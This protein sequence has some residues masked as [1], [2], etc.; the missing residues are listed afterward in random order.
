MAKSVVVIKLE[1]D[2]MTNKQGIIPLHKGVLEKLS[3]A[4]LIV[5]KDGKIISGN[6]SAINML[7]ITDEE[8]NVDDYLD[9]Q[10]LMSK[11][12]N[13]LIMEQK[14]NQDKLLEVSSIELNS[15]LYCLIL[16]EA[17]L[18]SQ[19]TEIK[20]YIDR[21]LKTNTIGLVM[22]YKDIIID[23]DAEFAHIFG[24]TTS[25]LKGKALTT[26]LEK[27]N[28]E[29]VL[30]INYNDCEEP[31]IV[32][33]IRKN[34][35]TFYA[36]FT[37][38]LFIESKRNIRIASVKNVTE[39]VEAEKRI[40]FMAN[41]D[42]LTDLPNRNF[43]F[44][45]LKDAIKE[46]EHTDEQLAVHFINLDYFKEINETFGYEVG[47]KLLKMC[48]DKFKKYLHTNTFIA[49]MS[50]DEF[51]I[52]Q[53]A[54]T[55]KEEAIDLVKKIL[56]DFKHP[57]EIDGH[58]I[59]TSLSIG[60]SLYPLNGL[61]AD[62]LVKRADSAMYIIKGKNRNHYNFF[63]S[64]I[65]KE[66]RTMIKMETELRKALTNNQL[67]LHY[68]PQKNLKSG[69]VIGV[70]ALLRWNHPMKGNIPPMD[71]IPLAEKTGLIVEIGDWVLRK[72]CQ[73]NK[74][75]QDKG[76][77][78]VIVSVNLSARQFHQKDV[79]DKIQSILTE[80]GLKPQ[81]LELEITE[82]MAMTN[83]KFI[84]QTMNRL[85]N[86]GVLVSIDDFGTGY[87]SLKS[88]SLFP[89]TKLKIDK[90]FMAEDQKHNQAIVRSIIKMSHSLNMKVIA[91]GVETAKQLNFLKQENCDE[92]QGFYFSKPLPPEQLTKFLR[93][94]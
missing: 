74:A 84:L 51:L 6:Q 60:I 40:E 77:Q 61:T 64:A 57:I 19:T 56:S 93:S 9:F 11:H 44:R 7:N 33:G 22:F 88:L 28:R 3:D 21:L 24:Y 85:R 15:R 90:M 79:V 87:S 37:Q 72:A 4:L 32:T 50:G 94:I 52:L 16:N 63:E 80:T 83:E 69:Q 2:C 76:Y 78:P 49:R 82:S 62:D 10:L 67:E 53:R 12:E 20:N 66:F 14:M 73:Q 39:K 58:D 65:S 38:Q 48:G 81:Y 68:Q 30:K 59:F 36:R 41:Y 89:V 26:I 92:M 23:C 70:E 35:E 75:W 27:E 42:V 55:K 5:H 46:A 18:E 13:Q 71:F 25:E 29:T 47:D 91:E 17:S 31:Y 45:V 43:F 54:L 8:A 34:G 1:C 86:L